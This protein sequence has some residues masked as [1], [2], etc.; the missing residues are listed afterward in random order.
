MGQRW[1]AGLVQRV[2]ALN[3]FLADVYGPREMPQGR[4]SIP[5]DLVYRNAA[6]PARDGRPAGAARH[7]LSTSPASTSCASAPT[8]STCWRTMPARPS[9]V[10]YMLENREVMMRLFPELFAEHRVAPV[11]NYPDE[12]LATLRSVAPAHGPATRPCVLLT[13]GQYNSAFYEHSL[14]G[15]QARHRAG[16]GL[17][18][19][20]ARR[21]RLHAHHRGAASAST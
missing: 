9:G 17:G 14:P 3:A 19:L 4:R 11:E 12:L 21:R 6:L 10:S 18:P 5:E 1:S 15:R 7:L 20:R 8:T 13:P 16:R 2:T